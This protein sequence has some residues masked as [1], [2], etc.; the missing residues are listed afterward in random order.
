V[1]TTVV[2]VLIGV[3][4]LDLTYDL[5][6]IHNRTGVIFFNVVYFALA[7]MSSVGVLMVEVRVWL[8]CVLIAVCRSLNRQLAVDCSLGQKHTFFRERARG[9]YTTGA[10]FLSKVVVDLLPLRVVPPIIYAAIS[11]YMIKLNETAPTKFLMFV[12]GLVLI[13]VA[14]AASTQFPG[15]VSCSCR[16][17]FS[18]FVRGVLRLLL[19]FHVLRL[20]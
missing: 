8:A 17:S 1:L 5:T 19:D 12:M 3:L 15:G 16:S 14:S 13:N 2:G 6:G 4:F 11:Y 20:Q 10:Y 7:S 18:W 9:Y